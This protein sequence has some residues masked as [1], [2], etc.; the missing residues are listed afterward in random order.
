MC[1]KFVATSIENKSSVNELSLFG[2]ALAGFFAAFFS[3]FTLCPT[4]LIKCKLQALHEMNQAKKIS[5]FQL[6]R[7][8]LRAEGVRGL[9]R[10]LVPTFAREM[11]GYF[12]FFGS[13]ETTRELLAKWVFVF[14]VLKMFHHS[15]FIYR[16]GQSKNDI[17]PL[18]TMWVLKLNGKF[19]FNLFSYLTGLLELW[20][21]QHCGLLFSLQTLLKVEFK[22]REFLHQCG[23]LVWTSTEKK[24][25]EV[26]IMDSLQAFFEQSQ[27][28]L[29]YS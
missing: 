5:P 28:Q 2:N 21:V 3:S 22:F 16:P 7:E 23:V 24:V 8:I 26:S 25:Y 10:G 6:T 20:E 13:Y 11:P 27:P 15:T 29:F 12:F 17:G 18:K 14:E 1:Q 9:F 19:H 4:E